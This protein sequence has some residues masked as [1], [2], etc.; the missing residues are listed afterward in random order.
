MFDQA[1]IVETEL[2]SFVRN[3]D[4]LYDIR[5][6]ARFLVESLRIWFATGRTYSAR[7]RAVEDGFAA[8]Q[9]PGAAAAALRLAG[10]LSFAADRPFIP[11]AVGAKR[12]T[13]DE[14]WLAAL[15]RIARRSRSHDLRDEIC[16]RFGGRGADGPVA[17][18][19]ELKAR[20]TRAAFPGWTH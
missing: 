3:G 18:L 16:D 19:I 14:Q 4:R 12:L 5:K 20:L 10:Y 13:A 6:D 15:L 1:L 2:P 17:D 8:I 11:G 9:A 7:R